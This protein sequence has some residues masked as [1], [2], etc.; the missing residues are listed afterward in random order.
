MDDN[1]V[2]QRLDEATEALYDGPI[3]AQA[4]EIIQR[5]FVVFTREE[6]TAI[7]AW[8]QEAPA[9]DIV[10]FLEGGRISYFD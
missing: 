2:L 9:V 4:T 10:K 1:S 3:R 8:V 7:A 5:D 6:R